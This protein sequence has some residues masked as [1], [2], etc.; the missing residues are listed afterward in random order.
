MAMRARSTVLLA[1]WQLV[2]AAAQIAALVQVW[3]FFVQTEHGQQLDWVAL[4][5]N[6]IGQERIDDLVDRVLNAMSIA[7]LAVATAVIGF[8]AL[9]RGRR[10]LALMTI[11]LVIGANATT[12][13]LKAGIDRPDLGI[14]EERSAAGNSLP[15]GHT[16]IAASVAVALVLVLP[17]RVRAAAAVAAAIYT[18]L[19]GVATMSA[20]WHRP[21]DAIA[22]LLIV[23]AWTA[24]AGVVL[25]LVRRRE[26]FVERG[27]AH[28]IATMLLIVGGLALLGAAAI[29]WQLTEQV[30]PVDP[31]DLSRR[32]LFAAYAGSAAGIAGL[33][34]LTM[35]LILA[36]VHRVVPRRGEPLPV[37]DDDHRAGEPY[38]AAPG[39]PDRTVRLT[40]PPSEPTTIDLRAER[41]AG[42]VTAGQVRAG[43]RGLPA[44]TGNPAPAR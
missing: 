12:Q 31:D 16:T 18:A 14:D 5:G 2:L 32:R 28:P 17:P 42:S 30:L 27:D 21:S 15:S 6:S 13:V 24:L 10:G 40:G 19:A 29:A 3:R 44:R 36:T 25:V 38:G 20:G 4:A 22:A 23:G 43:L 9:I 34:G 39:D 37:A 33:A 7:S 11:L 41:S 1:V 26:D 8:I 35:G